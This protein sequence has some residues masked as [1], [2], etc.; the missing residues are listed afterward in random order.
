M[1]TVRRERTILVAEDEPEVRSYLE[2]ALKCNGYA[3]AL[4]GDGEEVIRQFEAGMGGISAVLLDLVM[5]RKDG[6]E[7]L[8]YIRRYDRDVPVIIVSGVSSPLYVVEAMKSGA[9]D[10]VSKPL[11][12]DVLCTMLNRVLGDAERLP[13][14]G[15]AAASGS[16]FFG[17]SVEMQALQQSIPLIGGSEVPVLIHGETGAGKEVLARELHAHS[18]R[19]EKP[20]MK[21]NCAALPS[22]LVESELFGYERGAFTGAFQRKP[23]MFEMAEGGTLLLDEIGDMPFKLQAKL[24]QVLQDREFQRLGGKQTVRVNVRVMAATHRDLQN[25]IQ[26]QTFREDLYYRLSIVNVRVPPLRERKQ[27]IVPLMELLLKKH[28][29]PDSLPPV[30]TPNLRQALLKHDWPGNVRELENVARRFLIF[31][32]PDALARDVSTQSRRFAAPLAQ[33]AQMPAAAGADEAVPVLEEVTRAKQ[34]AETEAILS[35]LQFTCWNRKRAAALL[36]IE[37]KALLYKMKK[38]GISRASAELWDSVPG[39]K[40]KTYSAGSS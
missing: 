3:V 33:S 4:A 9:T 38:L 5:P 31:R 20:F 18:P 15:P 37:Y 16:M 11:D 30:V 36:K 28:A 1:E 35:M 22:E 39:P 10:F 40:A 24:L 13:R 21:L 23:G 26:E 25:A 2:M 17:S 8:R 7:T 19:A 34:K 32:D 14:P 12:P 29:Q 27:D 6:L